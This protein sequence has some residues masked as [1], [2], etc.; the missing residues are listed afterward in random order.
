MCLRLAAETV[1]L[2]AARR[3]PAPRGARRSLVSVGALIVG[4]GFI[5]ALG[6]ATLAVCTRLAAEAEALG[7]S[8]VPL[9]AYTRLTALAAASSPS[10]PLS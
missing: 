10:E 3:V 7:S 2:G 5:S 9:A 8:T 4:S 6:T 1:A